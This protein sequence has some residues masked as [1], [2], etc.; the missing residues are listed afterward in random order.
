[1]SDFS[2]PFSAEQDAYAVSGDA[3]EQWGE[4]HIDG[5]PIPVMDQIGVVNLATL[6]QRLTFGDHTLASD[7]ILSVWVQSDWTGGGQ[8]EDL[9][10]ASHAER[11]SHGTAETRFPRMLSQPPETLSYTIAGSPTN[12]TPVG[13]YDDLF[14]AAFDLDLC[15]WDTGTEAFVSEDTLAALPTGKGVVYDDIL[16]IPEGVSGYETWNGA[17]VA[18]G[19]AGITPIAFVE[20]DDKLVALEHDGQVSVWDGVAWTSPPALRLRG[21]RTPRNIVVWWS[22]DRFPTLFVITDRDVWAVDWLVPILYRTGLKFPVHPDQGLGSTVWRDD[23]LYVSVGMGVHQ[24]SLGMVISASGLDRDDGMPAEFRGRIVDMEDE[25]NGLYALVEGL[26]S[27]EVA[28]AESPSIEETMVR[29]DAL[30]VP[31]TSSFAR[32]TLQVWTGIGWHTAWQSDDASGTPTRARVSQADGEYR[33]WWGYAGSMYT[34]VLRRTFHNPRQG[35][36][37]S[38]DRFASESTIRTGRFDANL[39]TFHKLVSHIEFHLDHASSGEVDVSYSTDHFDG[40]RYLGTVSGTGQQFV[41]FDPNGDGFNEGDAYHWIEFQ[42]TLRNTSPTETVIVNWISVYFVVRPLQSTS[43]RGMAR[44]DLGDEQHQGE[45]NR[46]LAEFLDGLTT[47]EHFSLFK[48]RDRSYR[49]LMAQTNGTDRTGKDL[50]G[51]RTFSLIEV[52]DGE[53][54]GNE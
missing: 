23:S 2:N 12:A 22:A 36:L 26:V 1:V 41:R 45:G 31:I 8:V 32:S 14:Y 43:W 51:G 30:I 52:S 35:A 37:S 20:W 42:Y 24:L 28:V 29:D 53:A 19:E 16:W 21:D 5:T 11:F 4:V 13:D 40:F 44:L 25:Y 50:R 49:V 46:E 3:D 38:I 39:A 27:N 18:S 7:H 17:A 6:P 47:A 34:Q 54:I 48:H 9:R 15:S 33:I 10:E